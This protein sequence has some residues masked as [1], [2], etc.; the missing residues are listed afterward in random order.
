MFDIVNDVLYHKSGTHLQNVD[1]EAEF[2]PFGRWAS[3]Y[4]PSCAVIVNNTTNRLWSVCRTKEEWYKFFLTVIPK[5]RPK[6]IDYI[7][8]PKTDKEK[9]ADIEA[10]KFLASQ[11]EL[12]VREVKYYVEENNIDLS[13]IKKALK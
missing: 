12:S 3:M 4:S 1:S 8:K 5:V 10:I 13:A 6:R 2:V 7:K 9:A 11:L